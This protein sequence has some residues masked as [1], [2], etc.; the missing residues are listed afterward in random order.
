MER[1]LPILTDPSAR[2]Y[3]TSRAPTSS[4]P[5]PLRVDALFGV[6]VVRAPREGGQ[7]RQVT[8]DGSGNLLHMDF[9]PVQMEADDD[10]GGRDPALALTLSPPLGDDDHL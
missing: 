7:T 5:P 6:V 3:T 2:P 1:R 9:F 8:A 10:G 4:P